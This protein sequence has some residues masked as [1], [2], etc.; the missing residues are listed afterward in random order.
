MSETRVS[1]EFACCGCEQT[2]GVTVQLSGKA[3]PCA[4][5]RGAARVNVPCPTC[6]EINQVV[7]EPDGAV[8]CVRPYAGFRVPA[9]S[10]N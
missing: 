4:G 10:L 1:L 8:Q 2:V 7:F 6:G 5:P 3:L 9:P